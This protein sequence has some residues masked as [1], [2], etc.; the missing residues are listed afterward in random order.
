MLETKSIDLTLAPNPHGAVFDL[1]DAKD[2][3]WA[4]VIVLAPHARLDLTPDARKDFYILQ[5]T[6]TESAASH[7]TGTYLSRN[8]QIDLKAGPAGAM[9]FVYCDNSALAGSNET[10]APA[11]LEWHQ[12]GA[13]GMQVA[14]LSRTN[15]RLTLVSW[16]PGDRIGLHAH[17]RGEEVFVLKGELQDHR[18]RY[19]AGTWQ[20][21]YPGTNHAP[22]AEVATLILLRNGHLNT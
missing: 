3:R 11:D 8:A 21:L 4:G 20:R 1:S 15:H 13:E 17:P 10:V 22:F 7:Q 14:P 12:G 16:A 6:L 9:L 2:P 18:G 19:P 5:G